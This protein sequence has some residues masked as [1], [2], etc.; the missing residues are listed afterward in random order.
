MVKSASTTRIRRLK[1]KQNRPRQLFRPDDSGGLFKH[2]KDAVETNLMR[3]VFSAC[4]AFALTWMMASPSIAQQRSSAPS[5]ISNDKPALSQN[6]S[7]ARTHFNLATQLYEAGQ[8]KLAAQEFE[9]AY[10]LSLKPEVLYNLYA[11]YRDAGETEKAAQN[12]RAY[13]DKVPDAPDRVQLEARLKSL[14]ELNRQRHDALKAATTTPQPTK[15]KAIPPQAPPQTSDNST[16]FTTDILP[17]TLIGIGG[18]ALIA[19]SITGIL[20]LDKTSDI[21]DNC[22]GNVCPSDYDLQSN[23]DSADTLSTFTDVLLIGGGIVAATGLVLLFVLD[24]DDT[25]EQHI[26]AMCTPAFCG[27]SVRGSF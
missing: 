14:D 11:A 13:L 12:L 6:E 5:A 15:P 21:E 1:Q 3:L 22:P 10:Q 23:R 26:S 24:D 16:N 19:G 27:A 2:R 20:A 25:E 9:Q 4:F 18:A 17:W 7:L 8:F